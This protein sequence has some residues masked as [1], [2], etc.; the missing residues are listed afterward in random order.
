[1]NIV[2]LAWRHR[3]FIYLATAALSLVGAVSFFQL[4][5]SIY[6]DV[7]F[8]R[9]VVIA[10]RGEDSVENMLVGVTR[11][12]EEA[13][14]MVPGIIRVRSKTIRGATEM[15]L[16]F[17]P[18]TD[19]NM[20]L[21]RT[22]ARVAA[23]Q[24]RLPS[25]VNFE[26]ELQT[27]SI[28]PAISFN[29]M[30]DPS[31]ATGAVTD[32]AD[33]YDWVY[34]NL[35]PRLARV[36]DV[37]RVSVQSAQQ[38]QVVVRV[39]PQKLGAR[40]LSIQDVLDAIR[41]AN[42]VRAVGRLEKNYLQFQT[43]VTGEMHQ[44]SEVAAIPIPTDAGGITFVR[45]VADVKS[46][47]C[48]RTM[49]ISGNG[50]DATVVS[51]FMRYGGEITQL[52]ESLRRVLEDMKSQLP[53]G[54]SIQP[55]YDQADLV[56]ES[57][58]GVRD[59][60]LIGSILCILTLWLFLK[61]PRIVL[62]GAI[63]IPITV[64]ISFALMKW[65]GL[66]LNL[67]SLGGIAVGVGMVIDSTIV[68]VENIARHLSDARGSRFETVSRATTEITGAV[69]GSGVTSIVVFLPL[70]LLQGVV[71][72]FFKAL[73]FT[74]AI[75]LLVSIV[76]SLSLIP[77]LALGP[78][79]PRAGVCDR[80]W[81]Q[82]LAAGYLWLARKAL[83][84][85]W[86]TAA[87][88]ALVLASG[89]LLLR[90]IGTGFLPEMDEGGF[91]LDY[92]M[93]VGT[94]LSETDKNCRKIEALL[95]KTPEIASYSRRTGAELG[96]FATEQY[97]GDFLVALK[98]RKQRTRSSFEVIDDLRAQIEQ[99]VP[100]VE[101][102][103]VQVMQDTLN[104]LAGNPAPIEVKCFGPDY[105]DL[106]RLADEVAKEMKRVAGIVDIKPGVS[107]GSPE[108][109]FRVD[110]VAAARRG[111]TTGDVL[112]Q[113][114]AALLGEEAATL[115]Q[116]ERLV[117]VVVR[118]P[119][120]LRFNPVTLGATPIE[121]PT[122]EAA[123]LASLTRVSEP[124][125]P[126]ELWR[127]NQQPVVYVTARIAGQDLGSVMRDLKAALAKMQRPANTRLEYGGQ[128]ASQQKAFRNFTIVIVLS[129]L[130]V[131]AV[132][133][134][135]FRSYLLTA[136][137]FLTI[138][139]SQIGGLAALRLAGVP[140]NV[141]SFM[142]LIML[143]G[144]VVRN[145]IILV[146][147]TEQLIDEGYDL[148][149]ALLTAGRRRLRPVLM[150]SFAAIFGLAPLALNMGAGAELQRPLAIA[151]I[152]GLCI[153]TLFTLIVAPLARFMLRRALAPV[154]EP[155]ERSEEGEVE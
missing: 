83:A 35:K 104:D 13:V 46:G 64:V 6:P 121:T 110:P 147:Y 93:P 55:V 50:K 92:F 148:F 116:G 123:P 126:N 75:N 88:L 95:A 66:T 45:D 12:V 3:K 39:D 62:I 89:G 132:L 109:F 84:R 134:F 154:D 77:L 127:E 106:Q 129:V 102:E 61:S 40:H 34:L 56:R 152:G 97:M 114:R 101:I 105:R 142:G 149:D 124:M 44:A 18:S 80:V 65:A 5:S 41:N 72:Q 82:K 36:A 139:F 135:Q 133:V 70:V 49:V 98:P 151:A 30:L 141:S 96:F 79:G 57:L 51:I 25:G 81:V 94:S 78:L 155:F 16:D 145:G 119:D 73:S 117:P 48:D 31:K 112:S 1:M 85:P 33:L 128:Y 60:M 2:P 58:A 42:V 111:L 137:I 144:L 143:V 59:A 11:P 14:T 74:L 136:I 99:Q 113:A 140:L 108:I 7:A 67:I 52:S 69:V 68:V 120:A 103:F 47:L 150:T 53:P 63:S 21:G 37:Y 86:L 131:S 71:G 130:L 10:E 28:F 29:V 23:L 27:P 20:A 76:V 100:Q 17:A 38:R 26:V 54:V 15:S 4:P 90:G 87:L 138:P 118:Y 43:L 115:R 91:V 32:G 107:F 22:R 9:V 19:M 125:N 153:S 8:P 24:N 146:E 122:G